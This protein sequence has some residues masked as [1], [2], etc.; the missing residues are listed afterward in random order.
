MITQGEFWARVHMVQAANPS[1]RWGQT[2]FNVLH[3]VHMG[4]AEAIRGTDIDPFY[5]ENAGKYGGR[6]TTFVAYVDGLFPES[7]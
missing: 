1:W 7:R 6:Y 3:S 4:A 5:D 2:C